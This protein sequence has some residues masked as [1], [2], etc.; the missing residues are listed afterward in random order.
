MLTDEQAHELDGYL[1]ELADILH[2]RDWKVLLG[3]GPPPESDVEAYVR[4]TYGRKLARVFVASD[5]LR[6]TGEQQRHSLVHELIHIHLQPITWAHD[7]A[8]DVVGV[9]A[10][11]ILD[12][13]HEDAIEYATDGLA[14]AIAPLMPL[15]PWARRGNDA[16]A[17]Y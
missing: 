16:T 12:G 9:V 1:R 3:D 17:G 8:A 6:F 10:W 7:N 11:K 15:P 14:D 13:A 4:C 5:W 2:L